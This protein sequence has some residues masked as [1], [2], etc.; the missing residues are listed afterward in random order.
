MDLYK[1][2]NV[3]RNSSRVD[4]KKSYYKLAKKYHPDRFSGSDNEFKK[5]SFAY[6]ILSDDNLRRNYD[7]NNQDDLYNIFQS[8]IKRNNLEIVNNFLNFLYESPI[9]LKDDINNFKFQNIYSRLKSKGNLDISTT[10]NVNMEDIYFKRNIDITLKRS[11]NNKFYT[12][13]LNL[14]I[15][16][17]DEELKFDNLGDEIL[18][19]KGDLN[20]KI[21]LLKESNYYVLDNYNLLVESNNFDVKL[22]NKIDINNLVMYHNSKNHKIY[23]LKEYGFYD[24]ESNKNGDLLIKIYI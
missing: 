24:K 8:V 2:L 5:I 20:L 21:N 1:I 4:I 7:S 6:Q 10:I 22:F 13:N 17:Y 9:E 15:D 11:I 19:F 18:F 14:D 23:I 3:T 16:I 12:F